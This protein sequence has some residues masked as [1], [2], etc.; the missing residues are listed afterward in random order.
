MRVAHAAK[1]ALT[2]HISGDTWPHHSAICSWTA[3]VRHSP[4]D[5]LRS[6]CLSLFWGQLLLGG[7]LLRRGDA[8]RLSAGGRTHVPAACML[9]GSNKRR[10]ATHA[11]LRTGCAHVAGLHQSQQ[12][13]PPPLLALGT[14]SG[15][16]R[17]ASPCSIAKTRPAQLDGTPCAAEFRS[18]FQPSFRCRKGCPSCAPLPPHSNRPAHLVL[19]QPPNGCLQA[20]TPAVVQS[21]RGTGSREAL[22]GMAW[23]GMAGS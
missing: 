17:S 3:R 18:L 21:A 11:G 12:A 15:S 8:P 13:W 22:L 2:L 16:S 23:H 6:G 4:L 5:E 14:R 20:A 7:A 1:Q 10:C 19:L 9:T